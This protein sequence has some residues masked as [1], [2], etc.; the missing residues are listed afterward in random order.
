MKIETL[1]FYSKSA[2]LRWMWVLLANPRNGPGPDRLLW[3]DGRVS[4]TFSTGRGGRPGSTTADAEYGCDVL[5]AINY[6][7][8]AAGIFGNPQ[9]ARWLVC[10]PMPHVH[11]ECCTSLLANRRPDAIAGVR[12]PAN[13]QRGG[14]VARSNIPAPRPFQESSNSSDGHRDSCT[15]PSASLNVWE[16]ASLR[17][18]AVFGGRIR[19]RACNSPRRPSAAPPRPRNRAANNGACTRA[20]HIHGAPPKINLCTPAIRPRLSR[21]LAADGAIGWLAGNADIARPLA[22][23]G[24][25]IEP[26]L[27]STRP[28]WHAPSSRSLQLSACLCPSPPLRSRDRL[29]WVPHNASHRPPPGG[30]WGCGAARSDSPRAINSAH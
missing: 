8:K 7:A 24:L 12:R 30:R 25:D 11:I 22:D 19:W 2:L 15:W 28:G 3:P 26:T 13:Q 16:T 23:S 27:L 5:Q 4:A 17:C 6:T 9:W 10:M 14:P 20:L 21:P 29:A 18:L 1:D